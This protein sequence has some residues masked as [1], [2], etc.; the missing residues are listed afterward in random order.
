M[1]HRVGAKGQVVIPKHMRD[2]AGLHP[3]TEVDFALDGERVIVA[4][5]CVKPSL[6]GRFGQSGM[7]GRLL[8]DRAREPH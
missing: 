2:K 1:I 5:R 3:G 4:P 8:D 7:S 6:G